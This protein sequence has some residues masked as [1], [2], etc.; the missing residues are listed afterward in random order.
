MKYSVVSPAHNESGNIVNLVRGVYKV[1]KGTNEKF[2]II[3]VND[4]STDNTKE[5][6]E[7]LKTKIPQLKPVHRTKNKGVGNAIRDGLKNAKGWFIITLDGDLSHNPK[8]IPRFIKAIKNYDVVCGSRYVKAG[9][10]EMEFS[11]TVISKTF[12]TLFR[13]LLGLP[14]KDFTSGFRIYKRKV[15]ESIKLTSHGFG[16]YIEIPIKAYQNG[17]KFGEIPIHYYPREKG[18]SQLSYVKQGPEYLKVI[19]KSILRIDD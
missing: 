2:E 16:I 5:V 8:E 18:K 12:N 1:M 14:V 6:L 17:F 4:N 9:K 10:A 7:R 3:I 13:F 19:I 15:I 11:R